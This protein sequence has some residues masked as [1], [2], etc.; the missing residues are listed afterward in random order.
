MQ[1][2]KDYYNIIKMEPINK[3]WSSDKKYYVETADGRKLLL[4]VSN[5]S[6]YNNKKLE[7]DLVKIY[8]AIPFGDEEVTTMKN[9]ARDVLAW[10]DNMNNPIPTWYIEN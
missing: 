4:R 10:F 2:L 5:I 8:W 6:E 1:K 3:G 9:Q 7:F